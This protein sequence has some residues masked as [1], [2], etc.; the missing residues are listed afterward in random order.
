MPF[1]QLLAL[2]FSAYVVCK[3][4]SLYDLAITA[5]WLSVVVLH[6]LYVTAQRQ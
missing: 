4:Q 3:D 1:I 5:Q 6:S 2:E